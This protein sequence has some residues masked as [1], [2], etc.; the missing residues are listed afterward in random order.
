[1]KRI[2][3]IKFSETL[4]FFLICYILRF[5]T[6]VRICLRR[7]EKYHGEFRC[8]GSSEEH[9]CWRKSI[10]AAETHTCLRQGNR[11]YNVGR[12]HLT[13]DDWILEL[14]SFSAGEVHY[15]LFFLFNVKKELII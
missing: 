14:L 7:Q 5:W 10:F 12:M 11:V 15:A 4:S 9:C 8:P 2:P 6:N 1:M 13:F 3:S